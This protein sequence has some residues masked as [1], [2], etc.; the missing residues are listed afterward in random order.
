M[1]EIQLKNVSRLQLRETGKPVLY[2]YDQDWY[3]TVWQRKSGCGP[4]AATLLTDYIL[5]RDGYLPEDSRDSQEK[6]ATA[7][8]IIWNY[9]TPHPQGG[10]YKPQWL[11]Q[12]VQQFLD[13][14]MPNTYQAEMLPILPFR[15]GKVRRADICAFIQAGLQADS[16][17]AFLNLSRG[18][19]RELQSWHWISIVGQQGNDPVQATCYDN[20]IVTHFFPEKWLKSTTLGGGLVYVRRK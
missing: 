12:G 18:D 16:P 2:G 20:G 19:E 17:I 7:M 13:E 11:Q 14:R 6:R 5:Q 3:G 9:V 15:I 4:T 1:Q 8:E 10:L